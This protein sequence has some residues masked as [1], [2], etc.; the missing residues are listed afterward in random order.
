MVAHSNFELIE[1]IE[2]EVIVNQILNMTE[3]SLIGF[4]LEVDLEYTEEL[5]DDHQDYP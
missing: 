5:H 4:I 2:D 3:D 1:H